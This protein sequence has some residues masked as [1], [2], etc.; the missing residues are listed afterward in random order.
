MVPGVPELECSLF[1][2]FGVFAQMLQASNQALALLPIHSLTKTPSLSPR[3]LQAEP[4]M[5]R[6]S[7][8]PFKTLQCLAPAS[9]TQPLLGS[10]SNFREVVW[11]HQ[12]NLKETL[13]GKENLA[14]TRSGLKV[15]IQE[16]SFQKMLRAR[17]PEEGNRAI[18]G[19]GVER[20]HTDKQEAGE[21]GMCEAEKRHL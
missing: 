21:E 7:V 17:V 16:L 2:P 19:L 9:A 13:Q 12:D 20:M 4:V 11:R 15:S 10:K 1:F 14:V 6:V 3:P 8:L 5:P 18:P